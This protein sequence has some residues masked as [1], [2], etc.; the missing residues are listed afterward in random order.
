M[1]KYVLF[2]AILMAISSCSITQHV[3][4]NDM[5]CPDSPKCVSS[6]EQD[7]AQ[8]VEP[9]SFSDQPEQAMARLKT[10]LLSEENVTITNEQPAYLYAEVR[11]QLFGFVDDMK[12][13]LMSEQG[14]IQVRSSART[15]YSDLGVNR[16][17]IERIRTVFNAS[18][19]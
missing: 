18:N 2:V 7:T 3:A 16:R 17:R 4:P 5:K 19:Q 1:I 14:T 10:A 15:G 13:I 8:F 9:L 6:E 11:S 12:F